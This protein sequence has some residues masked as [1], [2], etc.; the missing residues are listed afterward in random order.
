MTGIL[1]RGRLSMTAELHVIVGA[2]QAGGHA[3]MAMREAGFAGRI[4]LVGEE[5]Y[6][7]Y[8]RPPL[9]KQALTEE[10]PPPPQFFHAE[11][12][13]A[14]RDITLALGQPAVSVD[15]A[16]QRL[17][18]GDGTT[19]PYDRLLLA[20]GGRARRLPIPGG[21]SVLY[22]RTLDDAQAIRARLVPGARVVCIG[23]GVIGLEI[24]S[25]ARARGCEV[26]VVEAGP[27][28]MGRSLT[29][30]FASY[31][32]ELHTRA[33]VALHFGVAVTG[34][35][36]GRV[37]LADGAI[38]VD[39][40]IAGVGMERNLDLARQAGLEVDG[41]IVV[42]EYGRTSDPAIFA[43]GD[44]AAFWHPTL[45]MRL[46]LEQW[47]H[48]QNHGI[49][50][51]R[52]MAGQLA[53]YDDIP[54]FWSDQHGVNLQVA[55]LPAMAARSIRRGDATAPGFAAF[56]LDETGRVLAATGVNAPREVRAAIALIAAAS[57]PDPALLADTRVN[58]QK[59][60]TEA[61]K[62]AQPG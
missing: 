40:V 20:T 4:V 27:A 11:Q 45:G 33:G 14:E 17:T 46:R 36:P 34:I 22:L 21:E 3:A 49:A 15:A 6:R 8:E 31:V 13:F 47:R 55:G 57:A 5:A 28:P 53:A 2:G 25:S 38:E 41:G 61:R 10:P 37:I 16:A 29:P 18:L 59:L 50:I 39:C 42:D 43:A 62:A 32:A 52:V 7:P 48:A 54:W 23:A 58:L 51:G 24:A 9:S 35:A 19:L 30:E 12:R 26:T 1:S 44:V 60:V 56:H